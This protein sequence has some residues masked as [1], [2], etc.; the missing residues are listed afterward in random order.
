MLPWDLE[1]TA[2]ERGMTAYRR[3]D[4]HGDSWVAEWAGC[5]GVVCYSLPASPAP[6]STAECLG[7]QRAGMSSNLIIE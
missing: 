7:L 6:T 1:G 4:T 2:P 3:A 5:A